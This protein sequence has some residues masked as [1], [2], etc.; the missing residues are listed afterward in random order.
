MPRELCVFFSKIRIKTH[1][2]VKNLYFVVNASAIQVPKLS[3]C[4]LIMETL[5]FS[6]HIFASLQDVSKGNIL[7]PISNVL[8]RTGYLPERTRTKKKLTSKRLRFSIMKN[9]TKKIFSLRFKAKNSF[10]IGTY[11][12]L[13]RTSTT[14]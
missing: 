6:T 2:Y 7:W 3:I 8:I 12:I 11:I 13:I 5:I 4:L 10:L 14:C 1:R 9:M